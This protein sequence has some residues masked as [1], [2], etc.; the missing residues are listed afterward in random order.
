MSR[1]F[2]LKSSTVHEKFGEETVILNLES[3]SYYSAQ[4][5][6]SLV[7]G[8]V[9]DGASEAVILNSMK[10]EFSGDG[11]EIARSTTAFLDELIAEALV[12]AEAG[13]VDGEAPRAN[14]ASGE[15]GKAFSAPLLQRYTDMEELLQ[16][17]P[18][19]EV[20]DLGWPHARKPAD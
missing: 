1:I 7:W 4:G 3:G 2:K 15:P 8:L 11:E 17:D 18:I 5:T 19:H 14:G 6:A 16:L 10:S 20:D 13:S 12:E 9:A